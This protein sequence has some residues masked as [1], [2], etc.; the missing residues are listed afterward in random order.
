MKRLIINADDLGLTESVNR[1]IVRGY[2]EGVLTSATLMANGAAYDDAVCIAR[3]HP[4]LGVGLHLNILRGRP[5][6]PPERIRSLVGPNGLFLGSTA[7]LFRRWA[8]GRLDRAEIAQEFGA[9]LGKALADGVSVSHLDSEKHLHTIFIEPAIEAAERHGI[10]RMRLSAEC[11]AF[12]PRDLLGK[13]FYASIFLRWR[14]RR[15]REMLAARGVSH[16][17]HFFGVR[18]SGEM[19]PRSLER[20]IASLPE[21]TSEIMVHPGRTR[22]AL[23]ALQDEFGAFDISPRGTDEVDA[24]VSPGVRELI[25]RDGVALISYREL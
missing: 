19:L 8:E 18:C 25:R 10:R 2:R 6:L 17:D 5:V 22:A 13:R 20:L 12:S 3:E 24:L 21:G 4:G 15:A 9:Q 11:A 23:E 7:A 16:P 14:A 1:A